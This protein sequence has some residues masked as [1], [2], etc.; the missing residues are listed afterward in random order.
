M[1]QAVEQAQKQRELSKEALV[2]DL[3]RLEAR[4]RSE[5]DVKA[6][7][8]RDGLRVLAVAAGAAVLVG[9]I[10]LLRARLG[11]RKGDASS[12]GPT[13]FEEMA[14]ELREIRK[15]LEKQR[16]G[17]FPQKAVLRLLTAAG[18]AAGSAAARQMLMRQA[19]A[20]E[21]ETAKTGAR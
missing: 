4:V 6:R 17:S 12:E 5:L 20:R 10:V 13:S 15:A 14:A 9:G 2:A 1:A 16:G 21:E 3:D 18:S 19:G 7:L 11:R 8:R